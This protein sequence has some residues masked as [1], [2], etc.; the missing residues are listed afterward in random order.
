MNII[1][2]DGFEAEKPVVSAIATPHGIQIDFTKF[3]FDGV[4]VYRRR[5]NEAAFLKLAF[6]KVSPYIDN[7]TLLVP[8]QPEKREYYV[9]GVIDDVETGQPSDSMTVLCGD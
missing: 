4:N 6:D 9:V 2:E 8:G 5:G 7:D 3:Q 1:G